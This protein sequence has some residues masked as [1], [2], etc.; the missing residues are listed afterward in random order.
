MSIQES[1]VVAGVGCIRLTSFLCA[2]APHVHITT[3]RS[4]LLQLRADIERSVSAGPRK[5][6]VP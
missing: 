5:L 3:E 4:V 6:R 2:W 1:G